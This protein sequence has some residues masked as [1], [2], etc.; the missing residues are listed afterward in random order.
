[1]PY[2]INQ[3]FENGQIVESVEIPWT[4]EMIRAEAKARR[5]GVVSQ[6]TTYGGHP[7]Q[8]DPDTMT[9]IIGA[10]VAAQI[11][12]GYTVNWKMADGEF[13]TLDAAGLVAM[14][15][16]LRAHIQNAFDSEKAVIDQLEA[17]DLTLEEIGEAMRAG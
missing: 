14:A 5:L 3:R 17:G 4:E 7:L 10:V 16:A 11:I 6:G 15:T 9:Q 2:A 13:L 8:A 12:P 1:M